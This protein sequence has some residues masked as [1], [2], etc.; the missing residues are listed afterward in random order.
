MR[1]YPVTRSSAK[2]AAAAAVTAPSTLPKPSS[3]PTYANLQQF[4]LVHSRD[5]SLS[6]QHSLQIVEAP[7]S[8]ETLAAVRCESEVR[9]HLQTPPISA[10]APSTV[11]TIVLADTPTPP[12]RSRRSALLENDE[13][14]RAER[15]I[16]QATRSSAVDDPAAVA[17]NPLATSALLTRALSACASTTSVPTTS[18]PP[19]TVPV[20]SRSPSPSRSTFSQWSSDTALQPWPSLQPYGSFARPPAPPEQ[21]P[22]LSAPRAPLKTIYPAQAVVAIAI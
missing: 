13:W 12:Y 5:L 1:G 4:A 2:A 7:E 20:R 6:P 15:K 21:V 11:E 10:A 14:D 22:L 19:T 16:M 3:A 18:A 9:S 17:A 8:S